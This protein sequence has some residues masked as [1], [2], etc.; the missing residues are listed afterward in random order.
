MDGQ[1]IP[2]ADEFDVIGA[3]D[4]LEHIGDDEKVLREMHAALKRDG[5]VIFTVPQHPFLWSADDVKACHKRRYK[6]GELEEKMR[7]AGFEIID[8]TSFV[9]L[10]LPFML[11]DRLLKPAGQAKQESTGHNL[12]LPRAINA[13]FYAAMIFEISLISLGLRLPFGGSRL[14]V[15]KK[16]TQK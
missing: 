2:F 6:R 16:T 4:C 12:S 13:L 15:G 3:F 5:G 8:S 10:L 11:V 7:R 1:R 9:T 14:V